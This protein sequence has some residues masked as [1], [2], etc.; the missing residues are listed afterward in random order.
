MKLKYFSFPLVIILVGIVFTLYLQGKV[1]DGVYFS[2]DAGL[3]ALLA[4]QLG[5]GVLRFDLIVP[6]ATW[7]KDL[8]ND[9][10]Y[11]Y[12]EPYVYNV[13][14]KYYI[15]FPYTFPLV[16][17]PFYALFGE[18]GLYI[19]P[20][21]SCWLVWLFFYL[22]CIKLKFNQFLTSL[23]LILL[24]FSSYLTVYSAMYWEHTLA[25]ALCFAGLSLW[26]IFSYS[27]GNSKLI[28]IT[29]GVLIGLSVW[30]RPEFLC[31]AA[32]ITGIIIVITIEPLLNKI[33]ITKI[34]PLQE[35]SF[36]AQQKT[37]FLSSMFLSV[38][39]FF[40][41]NKLI[42]GYALGIHGIQ[43]VEKP[44]I[45]ERIIDAWN[46]FS[47]MTLVLPK[48]L[49]IIYFIFI[50]ICF[51]FIQKL[52]SRK[53]IELN[54][55]LVTTYLA[56][57]LFIFAVSILVPVGTAGAIAG[58]K[59]WGVRFLLILVPITIL[60]AIAQLKMLQ[61]RAI[62]IKTE[63]LVYNIA[64]ITFI[65]LTT[66]GIYTNTVQ[67]TQLLDKNNQAIQPAVA[68]LK[69]SKQEIVAISHEFVGQVLETATN[70]KIF[71][72][73]PTESAMI[74]LSQAL[75]FQHKTK[76]TYICYPH[77]RCDLPK[78]DSENL[79]FTQNNQNYQ[80]HFNYLGKFGKYP[81]YETEIK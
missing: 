38:A 20:L 2:G 50:Y 51:Y 62:K 63:T 13:T 29:S 12:N 40:I 41:S 17:A 21:I 42:Y 60:V 32:V 9:G 78:T 48:Y 54:F 6:Q 26:G 68:F 64:L 45:K 36:L 58:G 76:F 39:G 25:V 72:N 22:D 80:I 59:Q 77:R 15:T 69:E 24:I 10:L 74:K 28:A 71:F 57:L 79:Q 5:S 49:P 31:M 11:P 47:G 75:L 4:K 66:I 65:S 56:A 3:K 14:S 73:V 44:S 67:A 30:F 46:N 27:Q 55:K 43:V 18:R 8:W 70:D 33:S 35:I 34:I 1:L 7:I 52:L 53:S 16:T 37:L 81:I 61:L 19:I 23:G